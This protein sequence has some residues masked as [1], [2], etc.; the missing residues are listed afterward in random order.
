MHENDFFYKLSGSITVHSRF[1]YESERKYICLCIW[2]IYILYTYSYTSKLLLY[3]FNR[4]I[5][6]K[7][8]FTLK[9]C[10]SGHNYNERLTFLLKLINLFSV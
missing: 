5:K 3:S 8:I 4:Y 7:Q 1:T 9:N 2:Q 10:I 6:Y